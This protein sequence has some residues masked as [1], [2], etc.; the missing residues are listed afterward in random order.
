VAAKAGWN[1]LSVVEARHSELSFP[2]ARLDLVDIKEPAS[3]HWPNR[4]C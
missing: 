4:Y 1:G 2:P 3:S